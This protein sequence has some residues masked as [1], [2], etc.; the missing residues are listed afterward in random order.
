MPDRGY[1]RRSQRSH[2]SSSTAVADAGSG[3]ATFVVL[4]I[5]LLVVGVATTLWLTTQAIADSY[6]LE[7]AK[8]GAARLAEQ[9][10]SLQQDVTQQEAAPALADRARAL[11]MVPAGDSAWLVVKPDGRVEVVGTPKPAAPAPVEAPPATQTPVTPAG[12]NPT[13]QTP[14]GNGAEGNAAGPDAT[15]QN[16]A[17]TQPGQQQTNQVPGQTGSTDQ[18]LTGQTTTGQTPNGQNTTGQAANGQQA[19]GQSANGGTAQR[20]NQ[21]PNQPRIDTGA[22]PP[23]GGG[24]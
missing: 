5:A 8:Q 14:V 1:V 16:P 24:G 7:K 9:A 12:E 11:G 17:G 21:G 19:N 2:A 20:Q 18:G 6:T 15:S 13:G 23:A 22:T 4:I 10:A 3:R